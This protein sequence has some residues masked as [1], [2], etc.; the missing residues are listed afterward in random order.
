MTSNCKPHHCKCCGVTDI[1]LFHKDLNRSR[2]KACKAI[3]RRLCYLKKRKP[4]VYTEPSIHNT[5]TLT[6]S[7]NTTPTENTNILNVNDIKI[8]NGPTV[9]HIDSSKI[10]SDIEG[11]LIG[12]ID[13]HM[14]LMIDKLGDTLSNIRME[15]TS[16]VDI[17]KQSSQ[18]LQLK[19]EEE[20]KKVK[21]LQRLLKESGSSGKG[22]WF[23]E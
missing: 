12:R 2:C 18:R 11:V 23:W 1:N 14:E 16:Q 7:A 15:T 20:Q 17:L 6:R 4:T 13:Q 22:K 19:L 9:I 5:F 21:E 8:N 10:V 3:A